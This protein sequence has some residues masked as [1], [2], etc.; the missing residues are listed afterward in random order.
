MKMKYANFI[1][2]NTWKWKRESDMFTHA[3]SDEPK[4][5]LN[6]SLPPPYQVAEQ[7]LLLPYPANY[8]L[9]C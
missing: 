9:T 3:I 5:I 1:G 2:I 4:E 7:T 8:I 6:I